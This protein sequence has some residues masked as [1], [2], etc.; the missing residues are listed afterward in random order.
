MGDVAHLVNRLRAVGVQVNEWQGWDGRGME[1]TPQIDIRGAIIHHTGT[2][3]GYAFPGLVSSTRP[4]MLGA[5]LCNFAG[6]SDGSLTVIASGLAWHAGGGFG[7]N[8]GPLA[9]YANN[10]NYYTV[11]LE[12]V[13]PGSQPMTDAQYRTALA[14]GKVV[15]DT[16]CGGNLE[17]IRGHYEVN[18]RGYQGKWDPGYAPGTNISMEGFRRDAVALEIGDDVAAQDVWNYPVP[19]HYGSAP[20]AGV[21]LAFLDEHI[22]DIK[23]T[24]LELKDAVA[25]VQAKVDAITTGGVSEERIAEIAVDAVDEKLGDK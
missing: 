20:P 4:D 10:R 16:F 24:V 21:L 3:Y 19:N 6:N 7:P 2:A 23:A 12:I 11:G 22:N 9:P 8:Q 5:T 18:G 25:A 17:C 15:A 1:N 13:Y 14:F